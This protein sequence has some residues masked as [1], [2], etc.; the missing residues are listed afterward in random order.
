MSPQG[1]AID[2]N[3]DLGEG[4]PWDMPLMTR[5]TSAS[6]SCGA[7]A[8]DPATILETLRAAGAAGVTVGA[9][10][11]F[12]DREGFGRR[13]RSCT[14]IEARDLILSQV[15]DLSA[16]ADRVWVT[17][18][19]LKPH[20][21]LY[22]QAQ[23]DPIVAEGVIAASLA[24]KLPLIGQPASLLEAEANREGVPFLAEGFPERGYLPDGA[25]M[26]REWPGA[27]LDD[28]A[29]VASQAVAFVRGA[30]RRS[31]STATPRAPSSGPT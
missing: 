23:R 12:P 25:L 10:P 2:L 19:F 26:P 7:H 4:F 1:T 28:P 6:V 11:G 14:S 31:A 5:V 13:G 3:A 8:G 24:L 18:R 27:V 20:G 29:E 21:A 30:S 17:L 22:N 16:L 9:H 15:A